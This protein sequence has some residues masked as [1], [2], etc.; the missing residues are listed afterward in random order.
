MLILNPRLHWA[1]VTP[2]TALLVAVCMLTVAIAATAVAAPSRHGRFT[3][4]SRQAHHRS[5]HASKHARASRQTR[6]KRRPTRVAP[7]LPSNPVVPTPP[8]EA[9]P[10]PPQESPTP[11]KESLTPPKESPTPIKE[12]LTPPKESPQASDPS[13][14]PGVNSG[15][16]L[17]EEPDGAAQIGVKVVR[18][19]FQV[20]ESPAEIEK[21]IVGYAEKGIRVAP[22]AGFE[23]RLPTPAEA[24]NLASWAKAF[25]PGGTFWA[26]RTDGN[27][28][29]QTIEFGNETSGGY[30]YGDEPGDASYTARAETYAVRL[31]EASEAISA[32]G[33][34][35]GVL[36]VAE[37][38]TGDWVNGMFSAV[39]N[40]GSYVG[41]WVSHLYGPN[42]RP[43]I[44]DLI[45]QTTAHGASATIPIDVTEWGISGENAICVNEDYGWNPCMNYQED[46]EAFRTNV[47]EIRKTLGSR[48]GLFMIYQ[49]RDEK[50][51][52]ATT[53]QYYYFGVLQ[54]DM[55]PKGAY[56]TA[57]EELLAE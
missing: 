18:V 50:P 15:W 36:A 23:G 1:W 40:L 56:T 17:P 35:V 34:K 41:G 19:A 31:K 51:V 54:N 14:Q 43:K 47:S 9:S 5:A 8:K 24:Q 4:A 39:P 42:W 7:V 38:P 11:I 53:S 29:I 32:T 22:L 2:L 44:E 30:Q 6:G 20:G 48:L 46:A 45:S 21:F 25:G 10:T 49:L 3:I 57:A 27:L 28:A 16:D 37:D 13:F 26:H 12:S 52:G 55:Q 33:I